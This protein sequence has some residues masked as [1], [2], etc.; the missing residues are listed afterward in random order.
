MSIQQLKVFTLMSL[1]LRMCAHELPSKVRG[2]GIHCSTGDLQHRNALSFIG[3]ALELRTIF[4][5][6]KPEPALTK[7]LRQ[8]K[9]G[10][11]MRRWR[12]RAREQS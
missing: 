7:V 4:L 1:C 12:T 3:N 9:M 10:L 11:K 5:Q 2:H 6:Q 8:L